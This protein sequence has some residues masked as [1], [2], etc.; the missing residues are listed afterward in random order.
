M[1]TRKLVII[2]LALV[3]AI[4]AL[5]K[6]LADNA[7]QETVYHHNEASAIVDFKNLGLDDNKKLLVLIS[8]MGSSLAVVILLINTT[9]KKVLT[10]R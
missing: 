8:I 5:S 7:Y 9:K 10:Y 3:F 4:N 6:T 1:R 2:F